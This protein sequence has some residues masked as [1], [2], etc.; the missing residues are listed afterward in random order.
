[1]N[2][3]TLPILHDSTLISL[4]VDWPAH[5]AIIK[6]RTYPDKILTLSMSGLKLVSA[7]YE[8]PWGPSV[9]VNEIRHK[10]KSNQMCIEIEMQSGDTINIEA[11][12]VSWAT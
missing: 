9:S 12:Q 2:I 5:T 4:E 3:S 8:A 7:P 11:A 10:M 6:F 1:M